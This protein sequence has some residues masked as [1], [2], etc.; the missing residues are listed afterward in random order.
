MEKELVK[1]LQTIGTDEEY[2]THGATYTYLILGEAIKSGREAPVFGKVD[3]EKYERAIMDTVPILDQ[4][5]ADAFGRLVSIV[6]DIG[7]PLFSNFGRAVKGAY[8]LQSYFPDQIEKRATFLLRFADVN[9]RLYTLQELQEEKAVREKYP[10]FW[11]GAVE[12]D[13]P[14]IA[15]Q[16]IINLLEK[17]P[18][19]ENLRMLRIRALVAKGKEIETYRTVREALRDTIPKNVWEK[20]KNQES[21]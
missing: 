20:C 6:E 19:K 3:S 11:V 2:G 16:E 12:R 7:N 10:W 1:L 15:A 9:P 17:D 14:E 21:L 8:V 5:S 13:H 4:M 18:S